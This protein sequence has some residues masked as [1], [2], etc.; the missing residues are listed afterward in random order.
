MKR[1]R[2]SFRF[3]SRKDRR[4][5]LLLFNKASTG[6]KTSSWTV[7]VSY[8]CCRSSSAQCFLLLPTTFSLLKN[9]Q[10]IERSIFSVAECTTHTT[11]AGL[12]CRPQLMVHLTSVPPTQTYDPTLRGT[13]W[14][15]SL[16]WCFHVQHQR[17]QHCSTVVVK[18]EDPEGRFFA[19]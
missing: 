6:S 2:S 19:V 10:I 14:C 12:E 5:P 16:R 8:V 4:R 11:F 3:S 7:D 1:S 9:H 17:S 13:V 18:D 15:M